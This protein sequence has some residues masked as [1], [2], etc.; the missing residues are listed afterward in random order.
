MIQTH[1]EKTLNIYGIW[2]LFILSNQFTVATVYS[3]KS[4]IAIWRPFNSFTIQY[5]SYQLFH[6]S[7]KEYIFHQ[8]F[9]CILVT[10]SVLLLSDFILL[11]FLYTKKSHFVTRWLLSFNEYIFSLHSVEYTRVSLEKLTFG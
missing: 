8:S 7:L 2:K 1:D 5:L 6:Q 11:W 3:F 4:A 10:I 9:F